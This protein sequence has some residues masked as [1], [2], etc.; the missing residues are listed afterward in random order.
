LSGEG[1]D[2]WSEEAELTKYGCSTGVQLT[3]EV[4]LAEASVE[5]DVEGAVKAMEQYKEA[6]KGK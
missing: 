3:D 5:V 1:A 4:E 2:G 6:A